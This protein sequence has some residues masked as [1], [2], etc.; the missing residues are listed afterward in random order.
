MAL[1]T[2]VKGP[3]DI[4]GEVWRKQLDLAAQ[5][6]VRCHRWIA[7]DA[8]AGWVLLRTMLNLTVSKQ[9][10]YDNIGIICRGVHVLS[11]PVSCCAF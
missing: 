2:L 8:L 7:V 3:W 10:Q 11:T 6:G 9:K 5:V 1:E 4:Q